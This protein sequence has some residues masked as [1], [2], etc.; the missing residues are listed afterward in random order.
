MQGPG[1][2][3]QEEENNRQNQNGDL[4]G[5]R[6]GRRAPADDYIARWSGASGSGGCEARDN[7]FIRL[8]EAQSIADPQRQ[9]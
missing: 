6:Q 4:L 9:D 2:R 5:Q 7:I 3:E 8:L 1:W